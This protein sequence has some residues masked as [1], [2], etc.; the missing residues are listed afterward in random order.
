MFFQVIR[1]NY[2]IKHI[3]SLINDIEVIKYR[4]NKLEDKMCKIQNFTFD[5]SYNVKIINN[6]MSNMNDT[7]SKIINDIDK[8]NTI[9]IIEKN[10]KNLN[11]ISIQDKQT[12]TA[13]TKYDSTST[14]LTKY[15][16]L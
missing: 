11:Y 16:N 3:Q 12:S 14:S 5:I 13:L 15:V 2:D 6:M 1:R 4:I 7:I 8:Q 10:N 9:K